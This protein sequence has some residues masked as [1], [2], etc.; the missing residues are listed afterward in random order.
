M[1]PSYELFD[2]TA[3]I[4]IRVKAETREGLVEPAARAV[5]SVIGD[6]VAGGGTSSVAFD[7][8]DETPA[9]LLRDLLA[10]LLALF[11]QDLVMATGFETIAFGAGKLSVTATMATVDMQ[12]SVFHREVKAITYHQ[13]ALDE[14]PDGYQATLILD[15]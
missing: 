3:D 14:A 8:E 10:E 2:H 11:D 1:Q 5:Y 15:I 4:G 6:L 12:E 7:L 13:L 9:V